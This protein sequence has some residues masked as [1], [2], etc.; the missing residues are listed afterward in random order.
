MSFSCLKVEFKVSFTKII[1][2]LTK[3]TVLEILASFS[4]Y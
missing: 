1:Y 4:M 3:R 2:F